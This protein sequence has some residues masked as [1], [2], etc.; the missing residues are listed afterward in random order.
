MHDLYDYAME[1]AARHA[2]IRG[3]LNSAPQPSQDAMVA[4]LAEQGVRT[5]QA[6]LSRDLRE[7]GVVKTPDGYVLPDAVVV[8]P[9]LPGAHASQ[10]IA[11]APS[12]LDGLRQT[13]SLTRAL[14][15]HLLG[16]RQG[17]GLVVCVTAP[18]HAQVI[19]LE[20]D[21]TP[22]EGVIGTVG[23]DDTVFVAV[24]DQGRVATLSCELL[25]AAGLLVPAMDGGSQ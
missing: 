24:T 11:R 13:G 16:V 20:L 2:V 22:P 7:L 14:R 6:T 23:G 17:I 8:T 15:N 25:E 18:G 12:G 1:R 4:A 21:R 10:P 19:A 5:T 9:A 3:L